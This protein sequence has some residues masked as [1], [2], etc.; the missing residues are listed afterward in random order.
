VGENR[1]K[2]TFSTSFG[3]LAV[4]LRQR[5][6]FVCLPAHM[7]LLEADTNRS[8]FIAPMNFGGINITSNHRNK[9][10]YHKEG[11]E[12]EYLDDHH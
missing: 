9:Q 4:L 7:V 2:A 11:S 6:P 3:F 12:E 8:H 10:K 1:P 5:C